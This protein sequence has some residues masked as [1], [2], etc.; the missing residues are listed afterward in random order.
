MSKSKKYRDH[1]GNT[2]IITEHRAGGARLVVRNYVKKWHDKEYKTAQGTRV[3]LGR[4]GG[5]DFYP[6]EAKA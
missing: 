6:V 4:L 5:G 2:A 1:Y 3:A